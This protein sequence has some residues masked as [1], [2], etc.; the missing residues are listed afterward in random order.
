MMATGFMPNII[1]LLLFLACTPVLAA[2]VALIGVI[3][4]KAAV[5][6]VDGGD[7]KTVKLGQSWNGVTLVAVEKER[8]TVE[9]DGKRRV[10]VLGQ[11][12][13]SVAVT[14]D[15]QSA[16]L[17]ADPRGHFFAEASV[18]DVP[19]R[20]VVDTGASVVV[21]SAAEASRLG[22]DWR[23]GPRRMI[24]TANGTTAGYLVKLDRVKVGGIELTNVDGVVLEQGLGAVGLLGMSFL[25]R[26][27]MQR[28]GQTMTLIR[29]F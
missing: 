6:A 23:R 27:E 10:L 21:L 17:A 7:P 22:V 28:D 20:F 14:S 8:A 12:Y 18:N 13:R 4:D 16:T 25:N 9:V 29:R 24:E 3:G 5:L 15:R 19:M 2:E 11:H 26:V 1:A